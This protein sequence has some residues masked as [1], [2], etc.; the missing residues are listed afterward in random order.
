MNT[1]LLDAKFQFQNRKSNSIGFTTQDTVAALSKHS[2]IRWWRQSHRR[3]RPVRIF[4]QSHLSGEVV[5]FCI[6]VPEVNDFNLNDNDPIV[7]KSIFKYYLKKY[8]TQ[9][10]VN[11]TKVGILLWQKKRLRRVFQQAA[12][13]ITLIRL[14]I[15]LQGNSQ[16]D[17]FEN[18]NKDPSVR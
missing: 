9:T 11:A 2:M 1:F 12:D 14:M 7:E 15:F 8:C 6:I 13:L 4:V 10:F 3:R 17:S 5:Y 16:P 18:L